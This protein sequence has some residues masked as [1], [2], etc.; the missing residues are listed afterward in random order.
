MKDKDLTRFGERMIQLQIMC[1]GIL[2][3]TCVILLI[4]VMPKNFKKGKKINKKKKENI[5]LTLAEMVKKRLYSR[6]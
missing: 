2:H 1:G 5:N 4:S 6:L 3:L